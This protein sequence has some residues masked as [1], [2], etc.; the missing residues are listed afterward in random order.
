MVIYKN[1]SKTISIN[2]QRTLKVHNASDVLNRDS[3]MDP[4]M[5]VTECR[6]AQS[7]C[8][9]Q[10]FQWLHSRSDFVQLVDQWDVR[11]FV[12]QWHAAPRWRLER[13]AGAASSIAPDAHRLR[14]AARSEN[15]VRVARCECARNRFEH[16]SAARMVR[17]VTRYFV[18]C[19]EL[20]EEGLGT[21]SV[22]L[23]EFQIQIRLIC[24]RIFNKNRVPKKLIFI[25]CIDPQ[26]EKLLQ[27]NLKISFSQ[28][29][30]IKTKL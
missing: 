27:L 26:N 12:W 28:I 17:C 7:V 5:T 15:R 14:E 8:P 24:S 20:Q 22:L 10:N 2:N 3:N 18:T 16:G 11:S 6:C 21:F 29:V 13:T 25:K 19:Q 4:H 9:T 1:H 30:L 23:I